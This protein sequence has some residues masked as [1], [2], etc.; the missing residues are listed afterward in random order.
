MHGCL[1]LPNI[2]E[3]SEAQNNRV[4]LNILLAEKRRELATRTKHESEPIFVFELDSRRLSHVSIPEASMFAIEAS[5]S[6]ARRSNGAE[7]C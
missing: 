4:R 1:N 3:Y 6:A 7:P 2:Y 5:S